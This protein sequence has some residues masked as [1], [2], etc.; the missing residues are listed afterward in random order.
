MNKIYTSIFIIFAVLVL[1]FYSIR[2]SIA[3][4]KVQIKLED[5][6]GNRTIMGNDK[7]K[8]TIYDGVLDAYEGII[9]K[10][11]IEVRNIDIDLAM[12]GVTENEFKDKELFRGL[13]YNSLPLYEDTQYKILIGTKSEYDSI[14]GSN[15]QRINI[16]YR[17][18]SNDKLKNFLVNPS[19]KYSS[20]NMFNMSKNNGELQLVFKGNEE[21]DNGGTIEIC[22]LDLEK[23]TLKSDKIVSIKDMLGVDEKIEASVYSDG[24]IFISTS[25]YYEEKEGEFKVL[26]F[27]IKDYSLKEYKNNIIDNKMDLKNIISTN[28]G[29]YVGNN[30]IILY[31]IYDD[32]M[33]I[34][35]FDITTCK[36]NRYDTIKLDDKAYEI[37]PEKSE[38]E[39]IHHNIIGMKENHM[40]IS[41]TKNNRNRN[42]TEQE[43]ITI[44]DLNNKKSTY[45]GEIDRPR[46][47]MGL[48]LE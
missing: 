9:S 23:Q 2:I 46:N 41:T 44:I 22:T 15:T 29:A 31:S 38:N 40:Y 39:Y 42:N 30:K 27:D 37:K 45:V 35:E 28:S 1:G 4:E 13:R 33:Y 3:K 12:I 32:Q 11:K 21:N 34:D 47:S 48:K 19:K 24:K 20:I 17:N 7:L 5:I 25:K 43:Y 10:D 26:V 14:N 16:S 8:T 36:F 18:K 6:M